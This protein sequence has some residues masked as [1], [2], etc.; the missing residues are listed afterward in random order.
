MH[1]PILFGI[2]LMINAYEKETGDKPRE[3]VISGENFACLLVELGENCSYVV[4]K[5]PWCGV[6][7]DGVII[8]WRAI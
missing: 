4:V 3:I 2:H 8:G 6:W 5:D 7:L 1:T